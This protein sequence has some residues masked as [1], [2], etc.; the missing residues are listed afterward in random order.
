M[1]HSK[2][3]MQVKNDIELCN[4]NMKNCKMNWRTLR[5]NLG[6]ERMRPI[7]KSCTLCSGVLKYLTNREQNI[8]LEFLNYRT[9]IGWD[10]LSSHLDRLNSV[11]GLMSLIEW[12][13]VFV[14]LVFSSTVISILLYG[15]SWNCIFA[16]IWLHRCGFYFFF[17]L[18]NMLD[19]FI[20][21]DIRLQAQ[22]KFVFLYEI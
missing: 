6:I 16:R 13:W 3:F 4:H 21:I 5:V 10:F 20:I 22:L 1:Q 19:L 15:C 7:F 12:C 8:L 18:I 14:R 11:S 2:Y 9:K 17:F